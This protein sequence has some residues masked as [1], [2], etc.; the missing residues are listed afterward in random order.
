[1]LTAD[2]G[3]R[4][5]VRQSRSDRV[6]G[7]ITDWRSDGLRLLNRGPLLNFWRAPT[8]NDRGHNVA[9]NWRTLGLDRVQHRVDSVEL[10]ECDESSICIIVRSRIAPPV[11]DLAF[12]CDYRYTIS[13]DG[14]VRI[15]VHG[16]PTGKWP[17]WI[18]RIGL[19]MTVPLAFGSVAWFGRGPGESYAD[20]KQANR[21]GLWRASLDELYTP[22]VF[23]QEN[24]NRTDVSWVSLTTPGGAGLVAAGEPALNFSAHRFATRD[25]D[26]A[27]HTHELCPRDEIT[28]NLDYRQCGLGSGS[29][30]PD[31][32]PQY[33]LP[34]EEF[35][36]AVG[37]RPAWG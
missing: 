30:G 37:L 5:R 19:H 2:Q 7:L 14:G 22:Y 10:G 34:A 32:L 33:R 35:R 4:R 1:M 18:P 28:L 3:D 16:T 17:D 25:F 20:S 26:E 23:P 24:G 27:R 29:C 21:F 9:G 36:F 6:A 8:D 11:R 15:E 13:P 12:I 31:A